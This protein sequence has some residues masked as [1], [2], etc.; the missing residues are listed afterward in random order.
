MK[1]NCWEFKGCGRHEGGAHE[2]DLGICPAAVE[3]KL[4]GIH[5]GMN[6]GRTCWVV[7]GTMCS[8]EVQGTFAK[9]CSQCIDCDFYKSVSTEEGKGF[10]SPVILMN[11]LGEY[12]GLFPN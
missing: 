4:D 5:G 8:G 10:L 11:M 1:K 9:K 7:A 3:K 2:K 6:A 12:R